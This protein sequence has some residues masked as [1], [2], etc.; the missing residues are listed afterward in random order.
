MGVNV[1]NM[2]DLTDKVAVVTGA[3]SGLGAMFAEA[4]AEAGAN[5]ACGDIGT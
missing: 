1:M 2:F 4:M 5:V 3:G